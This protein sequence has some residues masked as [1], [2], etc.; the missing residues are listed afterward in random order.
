MVSIQKTSC[1]VVSV[2][3]MG[4]YAQ[5]VVHRMKWYVSNG[6]WGHLMCMMSCLEG[7]Y[8]YCNHHSGIKISSQSERKVEVLCISL[9]VTLSNPLMEKGFL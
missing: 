4:S 2:P 9:G 6:E 5:Q 8:Y 3:Q 7:Q 1:S